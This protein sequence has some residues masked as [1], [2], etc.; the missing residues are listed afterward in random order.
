MTNPELD[1]HADVQPD[2]A[3]AA[4]F[5]TSPEPLPLTSGATDATGRVTL[6]V[7]V[8]RPFTIGVLTS[9]GNSRNANHR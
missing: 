9:T 1:Q 2:P 4:D 3:F 6:E 5:P 7:P 8:A